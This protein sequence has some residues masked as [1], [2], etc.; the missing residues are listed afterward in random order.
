MSSAMNMV[1]MVRSIS[2]D[3]A[4]IETML[5]LN[6]LKKQE[7]MRENEDHEQFTKQDTDDDSMDDEYG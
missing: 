1:N 3:Q 4:K 2:V 6:S 5:K 7:T